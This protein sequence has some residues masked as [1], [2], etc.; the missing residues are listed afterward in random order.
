MQHNFEIAQI[1]KMCGTYTCICTC[2]IIHIRST[3]IHMYSTAQRQRN[4]TRESHTRVSHVSKVLFTSEC[5]GRYTHY[6]TCEGP[7]F[8]GTCACEYTCECVYYTRE[9]GASARGACASEYNTWPSNS[10]LHSGLMAFTLSCPLP[11]IFVLALFP[12]L[13]CVANSCAKLMRPC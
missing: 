7:Q 10:S 12:A 3:D 4:F 9:P 2:A 8:M 13:A 1:D 6:S 5:S 11:V